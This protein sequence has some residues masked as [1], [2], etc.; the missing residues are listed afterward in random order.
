MAVDMNKL[1]NLDRLKE[2]QT[3]ENAS[4]ASEFSTSK[5]YAAGAYVYYKGK[6]YK[7]KSAHA[8]G[9]WTTT[10]VEEAKL[11]DDVSSLKESINTES[12]IMRNGYFQLAAEKFE[13]GGWS[14]TGTTG[15][16]GARELRYADRI[17]IKAGDRLITKASSLY[18]GYYLLANGEAVE[19]HY[20][21]SGNKYAIYDREYLFQH[22]G[23]LLINI[24]NGNRYATSS[25]ISSSDMTAELYI[26]NTVAERA[27]NLAKALEA[28]VKDN[29]LNYKNLIGMDSSVFYPVFIP[30]NTLI[31]MST[32]DGTA[33]GSTSLSLW[34]FDE[35]K[36]NVGS[37]NFSSTAADVT[38]SFTEDV[39]YLKWG[40][41][42]SKPVQVELGNTPTP[43]IEYHYPVGKRLS[44]IESDIGT[45]ISKY[46]FNGEP[47]AGTYDWQT[48]V[49]SYGALFKGKTNVEAFAFFTDPH[50]MGFGDTQRNEIKMHE[51]IKKT[52]KVFR[53]VPCNF[54][55]CGGDWLNNNATMDEACYRLGYIKALAKNM[56]CDCKLVLGNHDTNYQG[57][58]DSES[59]QGTGELTN[60]TIS[61]LM[62]NDTDTRKPYYSFDGIRSKCYVLDSGT[63]HN[64]MSAYD[65]E[66]VA[67]LGGKL[68][69]DDPDHAI[70]FI[71]LISH[72]G[73]IQ[74]NADT[75]A[76]LIEAYNGHTTIE[77]NSVTY[78]FTSCTGH[79]DFWVVGHAHI[80]SNGTFGGIPYF[81][82]ATNGSTSD[83][84]L[85]DL[86]F[87]DY[88]NEQLKLIRVGGTGTDR[89]IS[90][91]GT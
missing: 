84:P 43:Y 89:T 47:Y 81:I 75:F 53:S 30:A 2:F 29:E 19:T 39:Y 16:N 32:A 8:A 91:S 33:Y 57:K 27:L 77:L 66:Q 48:P 46:I 41:N 21:S 65:W 52:S 24:A 22:D 14:S 51:Y 62:F 76:D 79:I 9:A 45:Y 15:V 59:E 78:D 64:T 58:L 28:S 74:T 40:V 68:A 72:N 71:H 44:Q 83:V 49:T 90:L 3:S 12:G 1:V 80:D 82:T 31:T 54:F 7:F 86:V 85:I 23:E 10:D 56:L 50:I 5:S 73:A 70:I 26:Q 4:T 37:K 17:P 13:K 63:P 87:A 67:W 11:A 36:S 6:L 42:P 34:A 61:A 69:E 60:A 55:V 20:T 88:D 25:S 38:T 18:L 35:N